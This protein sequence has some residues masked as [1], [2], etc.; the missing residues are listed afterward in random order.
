LVVNRGVVFGSAAGLVQE[1]SCFFDLLFL[2]LLCFILTASQQA[3]DEGSGLRC[4]GD[5]RRENSV[6]R[7]INDEVVPVPILK[8]LICVKLKVFDCA[9]KKWQRQQNCC[10]PQQTLVRLIKLREVLTK[11]DVHHSADYQ[12]NDRKQAEHN[13]SYLIDGSQIG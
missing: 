9:H 7:V 8:L 10:G 1:V 4:D 12:E 3:E 11:R 6:D 2:L 5:Y 13:R